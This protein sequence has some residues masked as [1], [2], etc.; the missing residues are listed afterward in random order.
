MADLP[1]VID[2]PSAVMSTVSTN[3]IANEL[4]NTNNTFN[5]AAWP[6][7]NLALYIP[8]KIAYPYTA[9]KMFWANGS[10]VGT[11]HVDVG[12]YDAQGNQL[13]HSGSTLTSGTNATQIVDTTDVTLQPGLYYLAM[14]MD[15]TTDTVGRFFPAATICR[16]IGVLSQVTAFALPSTATMVGT[17]TNYIPIIGMTSNTTI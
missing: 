16:A 1:I 12:I 9:V 17:T 10:T 13:V 5:T 15:G 8:V 11:N 3:S 7:S 6:S 2:Y 4:V 14:A